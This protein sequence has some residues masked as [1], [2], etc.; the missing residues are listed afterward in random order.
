MN[1]PIC[2]LR[3]EKMRGWLAFGEHDYQHGF[4]RGRVVRHSVMVRL[5]ITTNDVYR[6]IEDRTHTA[7]AQGWIDSDALGGRLPV[8][9]GRCNLF[10][11]MGPANKQMRYRTCS[12]TASVGR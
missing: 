5:S 12:R 10:V 4:D 6:F 9:D 1:Q 3:T 11:D 2:R 8:K 7:D